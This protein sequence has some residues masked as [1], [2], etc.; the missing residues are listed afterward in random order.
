[1][2]VLFRFAYL[3]FS[4]FPPQEPL[5]GFPSPPVLQALPPSALVNHREVSHTVCTFLG[6]GRNAFYV[7]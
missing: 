1:M 7:F 2:I 6:V 5:S 4:R 3:G